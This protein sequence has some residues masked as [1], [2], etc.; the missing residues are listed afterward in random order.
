MIDTEP[1][2]QASSEAATDGTPR[3]SLPYMPG[4]DGLRAVAVIAVLL[5]H[6]DLMWIPGG[7][8]GVEVFFVISGYL[9]TSLLLREHERTDTVGFRAFWGR[10]AR[11]LLPALFALLLGTAVYVALFLPQEVARLRGDYAAAFTYVTNWYLI[12]KQES[13]FEA[14]GRPSLLKHLW[15][16]AV[17]EQ[18]YIIWPV[19]FAG[20]MALLKRRGFLLAIVAAA[21]GST[22]LMWALYE[23]LTDPSRVYYGTDTRAAGLLVG[24]ALAFVWQPWRVHDSDLGSAR[25]RAIDLVGTVGLAVVVALFLLVSEYGDFLYR[26]GFLVL[27]VATAGLIA[28]TVHPAA[29]VGRVMGVAPLRWIGL[30]SYSIYLWHWPVFVVTRPGIDVQLYGWQSLALRLAATVVL[31]D[32]SYR[33]VEGPF[34]RRDIDRWTAALR[35]R[36]SRAPTGPAVEWAM[37][38]AVPVA[39]FLVL[40]AASVAW[41]EERQALLSAV[42]PDDPWPIMATASVEQELGAPEPGE[43]PTG[44][45]ATATDSRSDPDTVAATPPPTALL[46]EAGPGTVG[47]RRFATPDRLALLRATGRA[48]AAAAGAGT[49]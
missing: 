39:V 41:S 1:S 40:S 20:G 10:R 43:L 32:L 36:L 18:F 15:S 8:L 38:A 46:R 25:L 49:A 23:P 4:L 28:A 44:A 2:V 9:I 29:W 45:P 13:Y 3:R 42:S 26:G 47:P 5:Y 48:K 16:L 24:A 30:R 37:L 31:A 33:L 7:F 6:A 22:A 14:M 11:R 21:L 17:E 35:S 12:L 27:S 19:L 34:R